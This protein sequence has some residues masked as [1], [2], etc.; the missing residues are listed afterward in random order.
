MRMHCTA[1]SVEYSSQMIYTKAIQHN[2]RWKG[3]VEL[4]AIL[5]VERILQITVVPVVPTPSL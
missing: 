5:V 2:T 1:D 4:D 3:N